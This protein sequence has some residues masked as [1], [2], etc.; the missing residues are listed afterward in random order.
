[1]NF[2]NKRTLSLKMHLLQPSAV[3]DNPGPPNTR[4]AHLSQSR[5]K[6]APLSLN[7]TARH[8]QFPFIT[9]SHRFSFHLLPSNPSPNSPNWP[10]FR[11]SPR[12][13][14][15]MDL[16]VTETYDAVSTSAH[17]TQ[18]GNKSS[19]R[20]GAVRHS[21]HLHFST[22]GRYRPPVTIRFHI[23][24]LSPVMQVP[25]ASTQ[26]HSTQPQISNP[27]SPFSFQENLSS[28]LHNLLSSRT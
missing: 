18:F 5:L 23:N 20:S 4:S 21:L 13:Q 11:F 26:Q 28:T 7:I 6:T 8:T 24:P 15:R 17:C 9:C 3:S 27:L 22:P 19:E 12:S 2:P 1:M 10:A 16:H 25:S 14:E